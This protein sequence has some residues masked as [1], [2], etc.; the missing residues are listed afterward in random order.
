MGLV[1]AHGYGTREPCTFLVY[2]LAPAGSSA[3]A[4]SPTLHCSARVP[5]FA[6]DNRS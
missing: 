4:R 1:Y 2:K 3:R 5:S 6:S